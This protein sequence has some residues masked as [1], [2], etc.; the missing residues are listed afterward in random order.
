MWWGYDDADVACDQMGFSYVSDSLLTYVTPGSPS[1][2][3]WVDDVRCSGYESRLSSCS[4]SFTGRHDC[5]HSED[6][7]IVCSRSYVPAPTSSSSSAVGTAIGI[8]MGTIC[9]IM[10]SIVCCVGIGVA[11]TKNS[12]RRRRR[13][14]V[15]TAPT[16]AP[17]TTTTTTTYTAYPDQ[18]TVQGYAAPPQHG[19][20]PV[21]YPVQPVSYP[22][23]PPPQPTAQG[24]TNQPPQGE[25]PTQAPP[26]QFGFAVQ[27]PLQAPPP[28]SY[29]TQPPPFQAVGGDNK[30]PPYN[31]YAAPPQ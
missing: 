25:Y 29:P 19:T 28:E 22:V 12:S 30:P 14:T 5:F 31:Y 21:S 24:F 3:I 4:G 18:P 27:P 15:V 7:G 2:S 23:Q 16:L 20:Q 13:T 1:Q 8:A 10:V 26:P 17:S 9:F 11:A 6:V